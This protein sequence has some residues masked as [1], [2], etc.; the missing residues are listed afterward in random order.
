MAAA[1]I[2]AAVAG[3]LGGLG[4]HPDVRAGHLPVAAQRGN[5]SGDTV[6]QA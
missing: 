5:N 6:N 2:A 3:G 1:L 4:G